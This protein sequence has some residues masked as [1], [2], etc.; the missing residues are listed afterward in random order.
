MSSTDASQDKGGAGG[1]GGAGAG[2]PPPAAAG[3]DAAAE[4][5]AAP[6]PARG[7]G[8]GG[9]GGPPAGVKLAAVQ[10]ASVFLDAEATIAKAVR[11]IHE[12]GEAGAT[13]LAFPGVCGRRVCGGV[14]C[15]V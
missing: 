12:A 3:S 2:S 6:A 10:A 14:R 9:G 1:A 4:A 13:L 7:G 5:P 15:A 8:G 11:L